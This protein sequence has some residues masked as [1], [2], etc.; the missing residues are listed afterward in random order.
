MDYAQPDEQFIKKIVDLYMTINL[1]HGLMTLGN[2]NSGK[3][4]SIY[5]LMEAVNRLNK[6]EVETRL[7]RFNQ[8]LKSKPKLMLKD[9]VHHIP[10][11]Y[12]HMRYFITRL[13]PKSITMD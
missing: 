12:N 8:I 7:A 11:D 2:A 9:M 3:T 13:D 4:V 1:R 10:E 6:R 5:A